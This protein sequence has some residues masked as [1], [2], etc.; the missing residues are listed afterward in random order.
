VITAPDGLADALHLL[1]PGGTCLIFAAG[2]LPQ[3]VDLDRVYRAELLLRGSRSATPR[4]LREALDA[5]ATGRIRVDDL[6][7]DVLPLTEFAEG[8]DRYRR[9]AALKVVFRP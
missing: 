5:I 6:I 7:T 2:P 4:H 9:G 3:A 1:R 8:L